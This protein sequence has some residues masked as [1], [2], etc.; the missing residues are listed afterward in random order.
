LARVRSSAARVDG[1]RRER[2]DHGHDRAAFQRIAGLQLDA[3]DRAR[4][5]RGHHEPASQA[6]H[7]FFVDGDLQRPADDRRDLDGHRP[8]PQ[9][10]ADGHDGAGGG[11]RPQ[12]A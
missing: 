12:H 7:A 10:R 8:R 3:T 11:R 6:R 4:H 2:I 1:G 9:E 5:R